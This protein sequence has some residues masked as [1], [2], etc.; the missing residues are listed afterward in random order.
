MANSLRAGRVVAP[1]RSTCAST[2]PRTPTS[3]SVV[4]SRIS[5]SLAWSNTF[6]KIGSV[7]RVL[8]TFWTVERPSSNLSLLTLNFMVW[9]YQIM[10]PKSPQVA[11]SEQRS[12]F[13][14]QAN[15]SARMRLAHSQTLIRRNPRQRQ[16]GWSLGD[17]YFLLAESHSASP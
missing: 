1:I 10:C 16:E 2:L 14:S 6:D 11:G 13:H 3:R 8:T 17:Q 15:E 7:V 4:V 5:P 9:G 12:D